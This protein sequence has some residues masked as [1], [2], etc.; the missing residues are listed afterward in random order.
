MLYLFV[1]LVDRI[2]SIFTFLGCTLAGVLLLAIG[3]FFIYI[4]LEVDDSNYSPLE[5]LKD[6]INYKPWVKLWSICLV[7][8]FLVNLLPSKVALYQMAGIFYGKQV[9]QQLCIDKKLQKVSEI[10]DLQ[11]DKGIRELR[12]DK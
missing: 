1:Y 9:S 12:N 8:L 10:I 6:H 3:C 5:V 4:M 7:G 11:L 2:D